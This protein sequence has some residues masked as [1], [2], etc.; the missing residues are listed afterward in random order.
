[1]TD[2]VVSKESETLDSF[3]NRLRAI[4]GFMGLSRKDLAQKYEIPEIT[5]KY[6]ELGKS[7]ITQKNIQNLI[8]SFAKDHILCTKEWLLHGIG[9]SPFEG[10]K[11]TP[12]KSFDIKKEV[13]A[14][15][16]NNTLSVSTVIVNNN[17]LPFYEK[18]DI[19]GAI[20]WNLSEKKAQ[21]FF[22]LIS[23]HESDHFFL[24]RL[25]IND[26]GIVCLFDS[27]D[28]LQSHNM[29]CRPKIYKVYKIVWH[30]KNN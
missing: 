29:I 5:L 23:F 18:G 4:R 11:E 10:K 28:L 15:L 9:P 7:N 16:E 14:F 13:D 1:M 12:L 22:A 21:S 17:F 19:V 27:C 6:W 24:Y 3:P 20:P 8:N 26:S 30:R 25:S 2:V